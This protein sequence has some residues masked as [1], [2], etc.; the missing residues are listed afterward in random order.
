MTFWQ[1][2]VCHAKEEMGKLA[3]A[4]TAKACCT[5]QEENEREEKKRC[6]VLPV[7]PSFTGDLW[8]MQSKYTT[9]TLI[10]SVTNLQQKI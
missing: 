9:A 1:Q 4:A 8:E 10:T 3:L 2:Q 6:P 7:V 5:D